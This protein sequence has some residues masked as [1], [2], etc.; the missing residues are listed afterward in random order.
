MKS[1]SW[2]TLGITVL[3]IAVVSFVALHGVQAGKYIFMPVSEA[4]S[5][6]LD[7]RGGISTEYVAKDTSVDDFDTLM[8][9]TVTVLLEGLPLSRAMLTRPLPIQI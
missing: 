9:G 3:L 8:D 2:I 4:I 5:L 1:R 7:L 6:G